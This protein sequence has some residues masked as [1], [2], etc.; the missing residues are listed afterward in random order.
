MDQILATAQVIIPVFALVLLGMV[1]RRKNM[2]TQEQT[3]GLQQFVMKFGLPCVIFNSCLTADLGTE[4]LTTMA[5]V[6]PL[7]IL[8]AVMAFRLRKKKYPYHNLP[9]LFAAQESGML[10]IPLY[11]TLFGDAQAYR[12]GVLDLAQSPV[13]I[14]TIAIL[15]AD[16]GKNPSLGQIVK[17]VFKSPFL[18]MSLLGLTLNLSGIADWL[19]AIGIGSL[20]TAT[21]SFISEPVSAAMLFSVGYNFSMEQGNRK[22]I[23]QISALHI[24]LMVLFGLVIQGLL[25]LVPNVE[26]AT[27]WAVLLYAALPS[28]YLAPTLGRTEEDASVA[29]GVCSV[30]TIVTLVVFCVISA[31]VA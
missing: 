2:M 23:F 24:G 7:M 9:Q 16:A 15:S 30:L 28:S 22:A 19:D 20:I 5:I 10:G 6:L 21:T 11:M 27:R 1:A 25:F 17:A 29:S 4:S 3:Q 12:M 13:A 18:I 31:F 26:P 8:S 14:P